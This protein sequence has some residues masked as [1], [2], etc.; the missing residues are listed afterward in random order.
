MGL[1]PRPVAGHG[2]P[3]LAGRRPRSCKGPLDRTRS[4]RGR[5]HR[6]CRFELR[7]LDPQ[8]IEI[9][10]PAQGFDASA[11]YEL[12]YTARDPKVMGL[13]LAAIRDVAAFLRHE[14]GPTNPL[15]TDGR[16]GITR[17]IGFGISLVRARAARRP[18][19]RVQ[20]G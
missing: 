6:P 11:L 1:R 13:A 15:A 8:R 2:N 16:T 20:S 14:T 19:F 5:P 4:A 12:T 18:V 3:Y 7:Y 17:S 9:T 10:R